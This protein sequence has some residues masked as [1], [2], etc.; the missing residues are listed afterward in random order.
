MSYIPEV[1]TIVDNLSFYLCGRKIR[2]FRFPTGKYNIFSPEYYEEFI[3]CFPLVI[4]RV[5]CRGKYIVMHFT[6]T[7]GEKWW[8]LHNIR[9]GDWCMDSSPTQHTR[10]CI[11]LYPESSGAFSITDVCY[12]DKRGL[13]TF[14]LFNSEAEFNFLLS[15]IRPGII[16]DDCITETDF[17]AGLNGC[18][19]ASL[20]TKLADQKS[21][22]S[23]IGGYLLSEILYEA[24][25]H[26]DIKCGALSREDKTRLY[27]CCRRVCFRFYS[28]DENK[29]TIFRVYQRDKVD[30]KVV[31]VKK[32]AQKIWYVPEIQTRK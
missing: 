7:S 9:G 31:M 30:R 4:S 20:I 13:G 23:G 32:G 2:Q 29:E 21:V 17:I 5:W 15:E 1:Q 6:G 16:G 12:N 3:N 25:L 10:L 19:S 11:S 14:Q 18:K 22:C 27:E 24:T 28:Q 26:P 8:L